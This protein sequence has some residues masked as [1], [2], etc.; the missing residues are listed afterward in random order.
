M[1][2]PDLLLVV[3]DA[4]NPTAQ[5][6]VRQ[7]L[8]ESFGFAVT[9]IDDDA[10]QADFDTAAAA[11]DV[12]YVS[13]EITSG[14]LGTKLRDATIGVVIEEEKI[15]DE[16]GISSAEM[17]FTGD[18]IDIIDNTHYITTPFS[19]GVI[20]FAASPQPVGAPTGTLAPGLSKLALRPSSS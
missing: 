11:S 3:S 14:S 19:P 17:T 2:R 10:S 4:A 8:I 20:A 18:S 7:A 5:D 16:F 13:E 9:L 15:H 1:K 12:A 6:L